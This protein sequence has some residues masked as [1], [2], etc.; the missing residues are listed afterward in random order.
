MHH[1]RF[2][3]Q[4]S[5]SHS[6]K[7]GPTLVIVRS[8]TGHTFGGYA[9]A[10]WSSAGAYSNSAECFLFLVE[11]PN[12]DAPTCFECATAARAIYCHAA[13]GPCF[14]IGHDMGIHVDGDTAR[15]YTNFSNTYTDTLG[16]GE[17]TFSGAHDF[18]PE[19]YEVWAV[20]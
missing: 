10:S 9:A 5:L 4:H 16:R 19:D 2:Y 7:Q 13:R 1:H 6:L 11:N 8:A 17:L 20:T 15:S 12:G 18:T 3:T 14:G